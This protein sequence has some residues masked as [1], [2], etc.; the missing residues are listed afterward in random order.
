MWACFT[1]TVHQQKSSAMP[2]LDV[3]TRGRVVLLR[4]RGYSVADIRRRLSEEKIVVS[5]ASIYKLLKKAK[6]LGSVVDRNRRH[7]PRI[8]CTEQLKFMDEAL[9]SDDELTARRLREMLEQK[10]PDLKVSLTTIKRARK[11]DLGWIRTRPKYC[12]LVRTA[13][14]EKRLTWCKESLARKDTFQNVLWTDECSVQL[15]HHGRLCFRKIRHQRRL[16]PKPKHPPKVH[17]WAGISCRGATSVVVFKGILNSTRYCEILESALLPFL[18]KTFPDGYRFQ[19]DNDPKHTSNYTKNFF[20]EN[21]VN[22]WRTPPESPDLNPIEN[23]WGSLKYFL[24]HNYKPRNLEELIAGIQQFWKS[25]TPEVCRKYIGHL[26]K[27][28][29]KV[30]E[31]EGAASGY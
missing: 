9:A 11:Y 19:Q 13:N 2:R 6:E 1:R 10:W 24:R 8:L 21:S 14:R 5:A 4:S 18:N 23:V 22:W 16:K 25:M 3:D 26:Q 15:D 29:P 17:I 27:V 28:M 7:T 20:L 31:L 30:V 12:Q